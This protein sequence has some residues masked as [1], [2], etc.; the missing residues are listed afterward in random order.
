MTRAIGL[1]EYGPAS[2]LHEIELPERHADPG[3]IRVA[4]HSAAVNPVDAIIRSGGFAGN[5]GPIIGAVVPGTDVSGIIEEIGPDQPE[6]FDL[7]VGDAVS[8][9]VVPSGDHGGYSSHIVLPSRS[10]TRMPSNVDFP[11]GAAFMSNALTAAVA[12]EALDLPSGS[13]LAVTGATGAVGGYLVELG[14]RL[15][16]RVIGAARP[17]ER[18]VLVRRGAEI[19]V[20]RDADFADAV[21]DA[22]DGRG[23]D[24]VADPAII[25]DR[26]LEAVRDGGQIAFFL[27]NDIEPRRGIT[28]FR[29][30]VMRS[31]LRHDM[32]AQ[33]A[34]QVEKGAL[35]TDVAA[36]LPA[37]EASAAHE[38]LEA[39]GVRGRIILEF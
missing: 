20:D 7:E 32:I 39:G 13:T 15:G 5:D 31:A 33:L 2:V 1:T 38:S 17:D 29:S 19:I 22:T 24:A 21:L 18:S 12:L 14:A 34:R 26:A 27:P 8:G 25:A 30:Y 3:S 23:A 6:G 4:V 37:A 10:V 36:I 35:T 16:L 11:A 28:A 9:F